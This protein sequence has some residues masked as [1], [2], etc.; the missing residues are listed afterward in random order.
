M[1]MEPWLR[2]NDRV[3]R[4]Q[5]DVLGRILPLHYFLV[6]EAQARL[7]SVRTLPQDINRLLFGKVANPASHGDRVQHGGS[8]RNRIRTWLV[9]LP[10]NVEFL[11]C[12][13][14]RT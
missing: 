4:L 2:N 1:I 6:I 3:A 11:S 14:V 13:R 5:L 8:T 10:Q 9:H 7:A 12:G